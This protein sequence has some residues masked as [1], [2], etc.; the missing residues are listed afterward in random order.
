[1]D[2]ESKSAKYEYK[3]TFANQKANSL[4]FPDEIIEIILSHL[5]IFNLYLVR[6]DKYFKQVTDIMIKSNS[7]YL[8]QI[9]K[10]STEIENLCQLIKYDPKWFKT[11]ILHK[12]NIESDLNE[13]RNYVE[14]CLNDIY[15]DDSSESITNLKLSLPINSDVINQKLLLLIIEKMCIMDK[16][17]Y[18]LMTHLRRIELKELEKY[19]KI[20][21][22]KW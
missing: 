11:N 6:E 5:H 4:I 9:F 3:I 14:N 16:S 20:K 12:L 10:S 18:R 1:M 21:V 2:I 15:F 7:N 13:L 19:H 17:T 22:L 8:H